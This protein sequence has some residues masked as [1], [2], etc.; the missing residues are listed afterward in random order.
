MPLLCEEDFEVKCKGHRMLGPL[1]EFEMLKKCTPLWREAQV[2]VTMYKTR[3][4][5][6]TFGCRDVEKVHAVVARSK[7]GSNKWQNTSVSVGPF[8][9]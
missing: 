2:E 3:Q 4:V 5:R 9:S 7:F 6:T 1:L 8:G